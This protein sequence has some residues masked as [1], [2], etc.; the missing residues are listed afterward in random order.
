MKDQFELGNGSGLVNK[1]SGIGLSELSE[2]FSGELVA[3]E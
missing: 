2:G 1:E 3:V